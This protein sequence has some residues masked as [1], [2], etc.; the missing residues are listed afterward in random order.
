MSPKVN[1]CPNCSKELLGIGDSASELL[2]SKCGKVYKRA[3]WMDGKQVL[4]EMGE[5][6]QVLEDSKLWWEDKQRRLFWCDQCW[7][8]ATSALAVQEHSESEH[9]CRFEVYYSLDEDGSQRARVRTIKCHPR[10]TV[11]FS[12]KARDVKPWGD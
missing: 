4:V 3:L 8:F 1:N 9:D 7:F 5:L 2:V 11:G 12:R 6:A 10:I